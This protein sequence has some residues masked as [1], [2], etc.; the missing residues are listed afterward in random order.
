MTGEAKK[1]IGFD[2][3]ILPYITLVFFLYLLFS[4]AYPLLTGKEFEDIEIKIAIFAVIVVFPFMV[5]L[6]IILPRRNPGEFLIYKKYA[7]ENF[8]LRRGKIV[9]TFFLG[10]LIILNVVF[11]YF[12]YTDGL[13]TEDF[14][15]YFI[16]LGCT[17]IGALSRYFIWQLEK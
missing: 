16:L 4:T 3:N 1:L 14:V 6:A 9:V 2:K 10:I 12:Y 7:R 5:Y 13:G 8:N 17:I 15:L 11:L